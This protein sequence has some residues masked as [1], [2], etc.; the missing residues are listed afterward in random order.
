[1]KDKKTIVILEILARLSGKVR[2]GYKVLADE[3]DISTRTLYR[4]LQEI[5]YAGFLLD[6]RDGSCIL[7]RDAQKQMYSL[8]HLTDDE[9][10][11]IIKMIEILD[12]EN[13]DALKLL[14]KLNI[15]Y[16]IKKLNR[17]P[18]PTFENIEKLKQS[19][20]KK[21]LVKLVNYRSSNSNIVS[22]RIVEPYQF[23]SEYEGVW[24]LDHKDKQCKQFKIHRIEEVELL[25]NRFQYESKHNL[26]VEDLFHMTNKEYIDT[27]ELELSLT[28]A[29]LLMEDFPA[30]KS[31]LTTS[32]DVPNIFYLKV[33]VTSYYGIG[34]FVLGMS[35]E[36]CVLQSDKFI[37]FLEA[38]KK[39]PYTVDQKCQC[40][41][42]N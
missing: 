5:E 13:K 38:K 19:M 8:F 1:M 23:I 28:A 33:P 29:N 25:P 41:R 11:V 10:N 9:A 34:R 2:I 3:F 16:D 20:I 4:Y 26:P 31:L 37:Q 42:C 21:T 35:G 30:S 18:S 36:V 6:R 40:A 39:E 12:V 7:H 24:C 17:L 14:N 32:K 15:I 27:V 22:D